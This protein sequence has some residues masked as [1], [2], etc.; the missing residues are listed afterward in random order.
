MRQIITNYSTCMSCHLISYY[1]ISLG[2]SPLIPPPGL[3][4]RLT[5]QSVAYIRKNDN[6]NV[7]TLVP[8][9]PHSSLSMSVR[10]SLLA[11][12]GTPLILEWGCRGGGGELGMNHNFVYIVAIG[13][14][15]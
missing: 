11:H 10:S 4:T 15:I 5:T 14:G 12:A 3:G 8:W 13:L 1:T 6:D 9:N 7:Y 2:T